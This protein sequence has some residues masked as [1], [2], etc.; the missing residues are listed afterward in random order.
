M[1][2]IKVLVV[3]DDQDAR[4]RILESL[5]QMGEFKATQADSYKKA[6]KII[7]KNNFDGAVLDINL[8]KTDSTN[9]DGFS[10]LKAL[11]EKGSIQWTLICAGSTTVSRHELDQYRPLRVDYIDK[12]EWTHASFRK[13][14]EALQKNSSSFKKDT[15]HERFIP[16]FQVINRPEKFRGRLLIIENVASW[17]E[18]ISEVA[19]SVE[20]E[21][22]AAVN[23]EEARGVLR[24]EQVDGISLDMNLMKYEWV[25]RGAR[26]FEEAYKL[27]EMADQ[28]GIPVIIITRYEHSIVEPIYDRFK[29][30][31]RIISKDNQTMERLQLALKNHILSVRPSRSIPRKFLRKAV[32]SVLHYRFGSHSDL[33]RAEPIRRLAEA[34][35]RESEEIATGLR[36][37]T[38][39]IFDEFTKTSEELE[40][41]IKGEDV[42]RF[43]QKENLSSIT[44]SILISIEAKYEK[45]PNIN[46]WR[47][48]FWLR[49]T[50]IEQLWPPK[51]ERFKWW[52]V[53]NAVFGPHNRDK[54]EAAL[55]VLLPAPGRTFLNFQN[56]GLSELI[57]EV[58]ER[59]DSWL[60]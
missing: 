18:R 48:P 58:D 59:R 38:L 54:M 46:N 20:L 37:I 50:L 55:K 32:Q 17:R 49:D 12:G 45:E 21:P 16:A 42:H 40:M 33:E 6:A 3:D 47:S 26:N 13:R 36:T 22:V 28:L 53:M 23:Y 31:K 44:E 39:Q 34:L 35:E 41:D 10:I 30:L 56:S 5:E 9:R 25:P 60:M 14:I 51:S 24:R 15:E 7:A 57:D 19:I 52:L 29:N 4:V 11:C 8:D 1:K 27:L 43:L 2:A